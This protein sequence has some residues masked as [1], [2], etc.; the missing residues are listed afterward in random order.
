MVSFHMLTEAMLPI[1]L[2]INL[3]HESHHNELYSVKTLIYKQETIYSP[4]LMPARDIIYF[5]SAYYL[6]IVRD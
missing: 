2:A 6:C 4:T 5:T 1:L 3:L